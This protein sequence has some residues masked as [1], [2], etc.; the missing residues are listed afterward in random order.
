[1]SIIQYLVNQVDSYC[2]FYLIKM[3]ILVDISNLIRLWD[4]TIDL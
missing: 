4:A 3:G 1:M 2:L